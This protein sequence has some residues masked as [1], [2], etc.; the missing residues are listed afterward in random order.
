MKMLKMGL[1]GASLATAFIATN[2]VDLGLSQSLQQDKQ[3][4]ILKTNTNADAMHGT[5]EGLNAPTS[6]E[7][8]QQLHHFKSQCGSPHCGLEA[9]FP[10]AFAH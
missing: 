3:L 5:H 4:Q 8:L 9:L 6:F 7:Y 1:I 10:S 2:V